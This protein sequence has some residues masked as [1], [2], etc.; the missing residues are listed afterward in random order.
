MGSFSL[1]SVLHHSIG[2]LA[3]TLGL[4]ALAHAAPYVQLEAGSG[5]DLDV[6]GLSVGVPS[7]YEW[8]RAKGGALSVDW[9]ARLQRW[10]ST[11]GSNVN[12]ELW[13]AG[14]M[15]VWRW[16]FSDTQGLRPYVQAGIGINALSQRRIGAKYMGSNFQFNEVLGAGVMFGPA[17]RYRV[18]L[19]LQHVSNGGLTDENPGATFATLG[20]QARF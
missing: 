5:D 13:I 17:Q 6:V 8:P 15:P 2:A 11:D 9:Q 4:S 14:F 20:F 7:K 18:S 1:R 19:D 10:H 16:T 12:R 3:L